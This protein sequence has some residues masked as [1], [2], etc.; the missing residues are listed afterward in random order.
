MA[1]VS[2]GAVGTVGVLLSN[3][4]GAFAPKVDYA[5]GAYA[6]DA[7]A[8]DLNGDGF[9]DLAIVGSAVDVLFGNGDGTFAFGG[10]YAAAASAH[11]SKSVTLTTMGVSTWNNEYQQ[12][13]RAAW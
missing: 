12:C 8:G 10:E 11:P 13:K 7:S 1:V 2:N 4:D 5:A 9:L 6:I 3:A